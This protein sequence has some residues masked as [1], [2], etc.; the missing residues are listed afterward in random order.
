[1]VGGRKVWYAQWWED[2]SHR[3]KVIGPCSEITKSEAQ[4]QLAAILAPINEG[5]VATAGRVVTFGEFVEKHFLPW[6][7]LAWKQSTAATTA[8]RIRSLVMP[9]FKN[10][11][12]KTITRDELQ[13][14]LAHRAQTHSK[15]VVAHLR[16][17]L[18]AIFNLAH[19]DGLLAFNPAAE[20]R[21]P[22]RCKEGRA[23]RALTE[24]EIVAYLDALELPERLMARLAI[25]EGMRPGEIYSL[26]WADLR[27][28]AAAVERRVYQGVL[29]TPKNNRARAAALS[30]G[31]AG[32]VGRWRELCPTPEPEAWVFPS[33]TLKTPLRA[34]NN[35]KNRFKPALERAGLE[36]ASWQALRK[37]NAT[38]M[39]KYGADPKAGADQRGHG[40]GV[41]LAVYTE[42][43]L[44]Q[45]RSAVELLDEAIRTFREY[46]EYRRETGGA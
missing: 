12:I 16:W 2:G 10:K 31:T 9:V 42:S 4:V 38:L 11:L 23:K 29:D 44:T 26:R 6:Q 30:S 22:R 13:R 46:S 3:G 5:L 24:E 14:F 39:H 45:K 25:F 21:V 18:S 7:E 43:G 20:L 35:W 37:T 36:W 27:P 33:S 8:Q 15:S 19:S 17:D 34:D 41:S 1:M 32:L 40:I 28:E